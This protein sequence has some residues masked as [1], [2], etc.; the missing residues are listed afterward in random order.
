MI[1]EVTSGGSLSRALETSNV[2]PP[3]IC[4]AIRTGEETG[5]MGG[6]MLY[7][8]DVLDEDNTEL[9]GTVTKLFEPTILIIMGFVVGSVAISLFLPMFDVTSAI[10]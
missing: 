3:Y 10:G 9:L 7:V 5:N 1:E 2:V 8:A 6:A 4:Q